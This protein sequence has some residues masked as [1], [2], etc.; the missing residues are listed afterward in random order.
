[1]NHVLLCV[2]LQGGLRLRFGSI[3]LDVMDNKYQ[4]RVL[5]AKEREAQP[6]PN[7]WKGN[8]LILHCDRKIIFAAV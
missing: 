6:A 2:M 8:K 5:L 4:Q 3:P 7:V 1:M